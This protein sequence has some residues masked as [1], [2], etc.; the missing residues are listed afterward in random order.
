[1]KLLIMPPATQLRNKTIDY[2]AV[3]QKV[4]KMRPYIKCKRHDIV[5]IPS[6][7]LA[8]F[9]RELDKS[10]A[11][12][13]AV[14]KNVQKENEI[15]KKKFQEMKAKYDREGVEFIKDEIELASEGP[16]SSASQRHES[17]DKAHT[18]SGSRKPGQTDSGADLFR[19]PKTVNMGAD[20]DN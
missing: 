19:T 2:K 12:R 18:R 9:D 14:K 8:E 5:K 16:S 10:E 4:L 1:M 13:Q 15:Q 17:P 20:N 6:I 3:V 7:M 11:L